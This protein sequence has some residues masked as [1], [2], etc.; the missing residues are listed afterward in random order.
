MRVWFNAAGNLAALRPSG[1]QIFELL[2][3][4]TFR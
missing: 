3:S 4:S 1:R 2:I